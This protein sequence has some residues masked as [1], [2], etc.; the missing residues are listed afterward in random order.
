MDNRIIELIQKNTD[1]D[2]FKIPEILGI[3]IEAFT[4]EIKKLQKEKILLGMRPI[5]HP[6]IEKKQGVQALIEVKIMPEREGGFNRIAERISYFDEVESCYLMSGGDYDLLVLVRA[7]DLN[8]VASFVYEKL[9]TSKGVISTGTHF[10]L[11]AYKE[12]GHLLINKKL[13][14]KKLPVAP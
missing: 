10:M 1:L 8:A 2:F 3:S 9:S 14:E 12:K 7:K 6:E 4:K 5:F 13:E 11:R